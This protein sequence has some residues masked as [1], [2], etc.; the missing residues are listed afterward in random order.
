MYFQGVEVPALGSPRDVVFRKYLTHKSKQEAV[1]HKL[2]FLQTLGTPNFIDEETKRKWSRR[3]SNIF[4]E[5]LALLFNVPFVP[6]DTEEREE[7][8]KARKL[9]YYEKVVK[10]SAPR[11]SRDGEGRLIVT[12]LPKL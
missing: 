5:Y 3:A 12:S 7:E 10:P 6:D 9:E 1:K 11:L 4:D 2:L 8:E